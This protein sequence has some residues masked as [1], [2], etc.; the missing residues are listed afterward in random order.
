MLERLFSRLEK[1][2]RVVIQNFRAIMYELNRKCLKADKLWS[3]L[4]GNTEPMIK[5]ALKG[6][7]MKFEIVFHSL[8][9]ALK[10]WK[11]NLM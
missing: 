7:G 11:R 1:L 3:I 5:A 10:F 6:I 4:E 2:S 9:V 8:S